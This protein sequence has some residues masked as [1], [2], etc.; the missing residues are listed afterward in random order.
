M[1]PSI[2]ADDKE[3]TLAPFV[4]GKN[5]DK[6]IP[7][8]SCLAHEEPPETGVRDPP[9][10]CGGICRVLPEQPH[11]VR[12]NDTHITRQRLRDFVRKEPNPLHHGK[13]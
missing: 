11:P 6:P 3:T 1:T 4:V 9:R 8:P 7:D 5:P 10:P 2:L 13:T 12:L